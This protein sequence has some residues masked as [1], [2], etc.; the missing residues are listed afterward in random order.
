[1]RQYEANPAVPGITQPSE[2]WSVQ[3]KTYITSH[4]YNL[5]YILLLVTDNSEHAHTVS[6][7]TVS[8]HHLV[9][10]GHLQ[11]NISSLPCYDADGWAAEKASGL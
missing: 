10:D 2:H 7:Y 4:S 11:V 9:F 1:M 6:H 5:T 3:N 8:T